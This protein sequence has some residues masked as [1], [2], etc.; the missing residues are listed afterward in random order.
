MNL[1]NLNSDA[2]QQSINK[3]R[4]DTESSFSRALTEKHQELLRGLQEVSELEE[5]FSGIAQSF[6]DS[7]NEILVGRL[8]SPYNGSIAGGEISLNIRTSNGWE[9][10]LGEVRHFE[11]LH[12]A[13]VMMIIIPEKKP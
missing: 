5:K 11:R 12:G 9:I 3:I 10:R 2:F 8:P 1:R 7:G 4:E 13:R 6:L